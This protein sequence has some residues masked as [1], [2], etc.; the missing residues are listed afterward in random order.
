MLLRRSNITPAVSC[1]VYIYMNICMY[2]CRC[3]PTVKYAPSVNSCTGI[4]NLKSMKMF[5]KNCV[6]LPFKKKTVK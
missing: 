3:L 1:L 4:D 6:F 5:P 2:V